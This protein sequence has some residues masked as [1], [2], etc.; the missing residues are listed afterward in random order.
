MSEPA[1]LPTVTVNVQVVSADAVFAA[2]GDGARRR[3]L[4]ALGDGQ[5]R[6]A[7]ALASASGKRFDNTLK[8]LDALLKAGLIV[9]TPDP[10]DARRRLYTLA[11]SV[12]VAQTPEGRTMDFGYCVVRL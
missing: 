9:A 4:V 2:L 6:R 8:H 3:I 11:P 1:S 10:A 5:L 7:A 12:K